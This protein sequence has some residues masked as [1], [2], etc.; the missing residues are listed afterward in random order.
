MNINEIASNFPG[1]ILRDSHPYYMFDSIRSIPD[2][3]DFCNSTDII[4]TIRSYTCQREIKRVY[5]VGCGTSLNAGKAAAYNTRQNSIQSVAL[6]GLD[7]QLEP[8]IDL[9]AETL[10][11]SI[12]HSGKSITTCESQAIANSQGALT[13]SITGDQESRLTREAG[14]GL[15]DPLGKEASFGKTRSFLSSALLAMLAAGTLH[16]EESYVSFIEEVQA[17]N[18]VIRDCVNDWEIQTKSLAKDWASRI[19]RYLLAGFGVHEPG[20]AEI[21]LK[22]MEVLAESAVGLGLESLAHGPCDSLREDVGVILFQTDPKVR[23]RAEQIA[24]GVSVSSAAQAII[25]NDLDAAWSNSTKVFYVDHQFVHQSLA[26]FPGCVIAQYLV[27]F[28]AVSKGYNPDLNGFDRFP[29]DMIKYL[30][31]PGTH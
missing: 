30:F 20:A 23:F 9:D 10:V 28:L 15:V 13:I 2:C 24:K 3:L 31:P 19:N 11:I 22:C 17:I 12:S 29:S 7:F 16:P 14:L 18:Q 27:Y 5:L 25:T 21:A 26:L 6:D 4:A 8:P 1:G